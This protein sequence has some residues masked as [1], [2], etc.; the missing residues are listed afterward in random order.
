VDELLGKYETLADLYGNGLITCR[1][2][3]NEFSGDI[4]DAYQNHDVMAQVAADRRTIPPCGQA[5]S[6]WGGALTTATT[7]RAARLVKPIGQ[8]KNGLICLS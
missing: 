6:T 4:E 5:S 8:V 2:M 3:Y 7:A 1:M